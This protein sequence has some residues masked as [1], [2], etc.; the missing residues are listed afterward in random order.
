MRSHEQLFL[1]ALI[2]LPFSRI[3][4]LRNTRQDIALINSQA[5]SAWPITGQQVQSNEDKSEGQQG[6]GRSGLRV[7]ELILTHML[8]SVQ[9]CDYVIHNIC[10]VCVSQTIEDNRPCVATRLSVLSTM[11]S[12]ATFT[13]PA[14]SLPS[15]GAVGIFCACILEH[16]FLSACFKA[17]ISLYSCTTRSKAAINRQM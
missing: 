8:S 13:P 12:R 2:C 5:H 4:I 17:L 3:I 9:H 16:T 6:R 1:S 10:M 14:L 7:N 11:N 15:P